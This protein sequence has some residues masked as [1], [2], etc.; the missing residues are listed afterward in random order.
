[1]LTRG[2]R[3]VW[4]V[5]RGTNGLRQSIVAKVPHDADDGRQR[6]LL[7]AHAHALA[8]GVRAAEPFLYHLLIDEH[9][10][11]ERVVVSLGKPASAKERH[12]DRLEVVGRDVLVMRDEFLARLRLRRTFDARLSLDVP[13]AEWNAL[14]RGNRGDARLRAQAREQF[15]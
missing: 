8:D 11:I 12:A 4:K 3:G 6:T 9:H 1:M 5:P 2:T 14:G 10:R 13:A 7:S 15:V